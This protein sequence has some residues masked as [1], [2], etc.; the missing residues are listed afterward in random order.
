LGYGTQYGDLAS[1]INPLGDLYK[2]QVYQLAKF[3]GVPEEIYNKPPSA[4]LWMGQTD[5]AELG[6]PYSELDRLLYYMIDQRYDLSKLEALG[7]DQEMLSTIQA[8]IRLNQ[9]KRRLPIIL[10]LSPRTVGVDFR[11]PRDWGV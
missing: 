11:Y 4:D 9:Y 5:E 1:A 6:Y 2:T 7:F 3:L 8:R 10:K